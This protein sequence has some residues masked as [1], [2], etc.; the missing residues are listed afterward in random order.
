MFWD[1]LYYVHLMP[2]VV[3]IKIC[4]VLFYCSFYNEVIA[5]I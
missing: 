4:S 3:G 5:N 2:G 1:G